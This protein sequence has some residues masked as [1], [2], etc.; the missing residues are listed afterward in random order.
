MASVRLC[1]TIVSVA[2]QAIG[3][4][5][6]TLRATG[7]GTYREQSFDAP[8]DW[9]NRSTLLTENR[10]MWKTA[11]SQLLKTKTATGEFFDYA[12][13][14]V[15]ATVLE[16]EEVTENINFNVGGQRIDRNAYLNVAKMI[17]AGKIQVRYAP[18]NFDTY[19]CATNTLTFKSYDTTSIPR[20]SFI[21]H[22]ATHAIHDMGAL[23]NVLNEDFEAASYI[24]Q[25]IYLV[26]QGYKAGNL[27][28]SDTELL[29]AM[30]TVEVWDSKYPDKISKKELEYMKK[31]LQAG[32]NYSH[33]GKLVPLNGIPN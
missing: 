4:N 33:I 11:E 7:D 12:F 18:G 26:G 31:A 5:R 9:D 22:E 29:E 30:V 20:R 23:K 28:S 8:S 32:G 15:V 27:L 17:R 13:G 10:L 1:Q 24:A 19:D 16:D 3:D 6:S 25:A 2:L 21:V 14:V